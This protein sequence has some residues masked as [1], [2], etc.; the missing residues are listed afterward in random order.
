M[1]VL[2]LHK[3]SE[4]Q[5]IIKFEWQS[6]SNFYNHQLNFTFKN[7]YNSIK[8]LNKKYQNSKQIFINYKYVNFSNVINNVDNKS[9]K[10]QIDQ[11]N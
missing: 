8:Y 11:K 5:S 9:H 2:L 4:N 7:E 1:L 3:I 10:V 6:L